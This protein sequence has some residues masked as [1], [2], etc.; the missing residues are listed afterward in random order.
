[1]NAADMVAR[2][3]EAPAELL[4]FLPELLAD[5]DELGSDSKQIV[6]ILR[7]LPLPAGARV[8]DVGCG[9]AGGRFA[10]VRV[11]PWGRES[12]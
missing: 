9:K 3:L 7:E 8:V 11:P 5:V 10:P 4:P 6:S 12:A 1:M 2:A